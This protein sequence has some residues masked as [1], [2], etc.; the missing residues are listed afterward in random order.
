M[1]SQYEDS[2]D[3][4]QKMDGGQTREAESKV[5]GNRGCPRALRSSNSR[6]VRFPAASGQN[7]QNFDIQK[8]DD[9]TI[10]KQRIPTDER[11]C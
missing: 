1:S 9:S 7:I 8:K 4:M 3:S 2:G 11:V 10:H 5:A 6:T